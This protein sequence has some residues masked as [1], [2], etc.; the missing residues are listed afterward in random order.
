MVLG[1][2]FAALGSLTIYTAS[3]W[4]AAVDDGISRSSES[5]HQ[6]PVFQAN[7]KRIYEV[8]TDPRKFDE[9][10]RLSA[11]YALGRDPE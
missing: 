6:E 11:A 3:S 5:I 9:V 1:G 10:V 4:A 2:T 8:L 7:R